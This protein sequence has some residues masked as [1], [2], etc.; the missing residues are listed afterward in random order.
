MSYA[1]TAA[2]NVVCRH[3]AQG[4]HCRFAERCR[5]LHSTAAPPRPLR[6]GAQ[7]GSAGGLSVPQHKRARRDNPR[8]QHA[9]RRRWIP[10]ELAEGTEESRFKV[11]NLNLLADSL[12]T[13]EHYPGTPKRFL[14]WQYRSGGLMKHILSS[15]ADLLCLQE[16]DHAHFESFY[17]PQLEAAGY[18]G[19]FKCRTGDKRDG[20][21]VF[22]RGASFSVSDWV[23]VE[24]FVAG[25][26]VLDRDNVALGAVC[27]H[28]ATGRTLL[29]ATTHLLFNPK[30]GDVKIAQLNFLTEMLQRVRADHGH[31]PVILTGDFNSTPVS[32]VYEVMTRGQLDASHVDR[33]EVSGQGEVIRQMSR[34]GKR[35]PPP[36]DR[37]GP[38]GA[39]GTALGQFKPPS[40]PSSPR[41]VP[42]PAELSQPKCALGPMKSAY[43]LPSNG[44]S[45]GEPAFTTYHFN[46]KG[47]VDYVFYADSESQP[48]RPAGILGMPTPAQLGQMGVPNEV[49]S[50][51]HLSLLTEFSFGQPPRENSATSM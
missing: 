32:A 35:R 19:Q 13:F 37:D 2:R 15:D 22:V 6:R 10:G 18:R 38:H 43:A 27:T 25:H 51:D 41:F 20:C 8:R 30:R 46:F 50:S 3:F 42:L 12:V 26:P 4:G 34:G 47:A 45:T 7:D 1:Q 33:R 5:F 9:F 11:L 44:G 39:S 17:S 28:K 21:A 49:W 36:Y 14:S 23:Q 40:P 31:C 16:V 48:L 24:C 29:V